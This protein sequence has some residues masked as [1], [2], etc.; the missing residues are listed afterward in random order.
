MPE[1]I[2]FIL[3]YLG[4]FIV[5]PVLFLKFFLLRK[6]E[7]KETNQQTDTK[8]PFGRLKYFLWIFGIGLVAS[9]SMAVFDYPLGVIVFAQLCAIAAMAKRFGDI[10]FSKWWAILG[11]TFFFP[12]LIVIVGAWAHILCLITPA[13]VR[14]SIQNKEL[15]E[16][17][18]GAVEGLQHEGCRKRKL[19][20]LSIRM[21]RE[22]LIIGCLLAIPIAIALISF[23]AHQNAIN[24]E[25]SPLILATELNPNRSYVWE[26]LAE[27]AYFFDKYSMAENASRKAIAL[28][29]RK[30]GYLL[31]GK[32]YRDQKKYEKAIYCFQRSADYYAKIHLGDLY[33]KLG[34]YEE[35]TEQYLKAI[36]LLKETIKEDAIWLDASWVDWN[37]LGDVYLKIGEKEKAYDAFATALTLGEDLD[38]I[39]EKMTT[40]AP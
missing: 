25:L 26:H 23:L 4:V 9:F 22:T 37:K 35:S 11:L 7:K 33:Q 38:F 13:L 27:R 8:K 6:Y 10:G 29:A 1:L 18:V 30:D 28:G 15:P 16:A 5:P 32:I 3:L 34:S 17:T 24:K 31:L 12:S 2:Q 20:F 40:I 14:K 21:K 19:K 36:D 39:K